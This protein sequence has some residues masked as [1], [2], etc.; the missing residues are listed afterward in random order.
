MS[1]RFIQ[2]LSKEID[3]GASKMKPSLNKK[4][5]KVCCLKALAQFEST[6]HLQTQQFSKDIVC[7]ECGELYSVKWKFC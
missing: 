4:P 1:D 6:Q 3:K 5:K 2:Y 7:H